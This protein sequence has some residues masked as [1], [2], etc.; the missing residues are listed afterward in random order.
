MTYCKK[1]N[2][3]H[4]LIEITMDDY[5]EYTPIVMRRKFAP[6]HSIE[7]QIYKAALMAKQDGV[8]LMI[9]RE[10][11]DLIFGGMDKLITPEWTF[12]AFVK[13]YTFLDPKL[14]LSHPVDQ[15]GPSAAE[16]DAR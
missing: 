15:S 5:V 1:F 13:R 14:V 3:N 7:P 6:V 10:S 12:D 2:L 9:V 4:H 16:R 11:S 8:Q